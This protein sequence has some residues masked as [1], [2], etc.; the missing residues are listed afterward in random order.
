MKAPRSIKISTTKELL[1]IKAE[2]KMKYSNHQP[3]DIPENIVID[4]TCPTSDL[5]ILLPPQEELLI[6][7]QKRFQFGDRFTLDD[8]FD[9]EDI[10][11]SIYNDA[12][13]IKIYAELKEDKIKC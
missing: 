6:L 4:A 2:M 10:Q 9:V 5:K 8:E 11:I 12:L 7:V 3:T 1:F 13:T